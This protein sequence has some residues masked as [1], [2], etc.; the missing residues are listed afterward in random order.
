MRTRAAHFFFAFMGFAIAA[1][2]QEGPSPM[3][4]A[5]LFDATRLRTGEFH[6]RVVKDGKEVSRSVLIIQKQTDANFRFTAEFD[7][8]NQQWLSIATV[9]FA[10]IR[11]Q[12]RSDGANGG[13]YSM[14]VVYEKGRATASVSRWKLETSS[15][16]R[17]KKITADVPLG[18]V[19]Q[20]IDWAAMLSSPL[21]D[22]QKFEFTV[23]DP[24]TG[25]S[26]VSAS[27]AGKEEIQVPAGTFETIRANY[28]I[29][30][31]SGPETYTIFASKDVPRVLVREDFQNGE[32][33]QLTK[34]DGDYGSK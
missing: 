10:P 26:H 33:L 20:R 30:K 6:Y 5:P 13:K 16:S 34:I 28:R 22:G 23:Y 12:L 25:I 14:D 2:G 11:A 15:A 31:S 19:D 4:T 1:L 3:A 29:E 27:V 21:P 9:A 7:G 32:S 8:F 18:T 17:G 24:E